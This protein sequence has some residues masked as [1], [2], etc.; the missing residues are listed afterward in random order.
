[1]PRLRLLALAAL[2]LCLAQ[3]PAAAQ[4]PQGWQTEPGGAKAPANTTV[5]PRSTLLPKG[6]GGTGQVSLTAHLTEESQGISQGLVWRVFRDQPGSDAKPAFLSMHKEAAPTLRLEA[7]TYLINVTLGRANLTRKI[8]VAA[9]ERVAKE[10]FVLNAGGLRVIAVLPPNTAPSERIVAFDVQS[11]ELD[12]HGQRTKVVTGAKPGVVLRLNAGIYS[13]VSRFGD[14][15]AL[16]R[17]DI[18]VE[19][20]K[21]S[22]VTLVHAAAKVSFKLVTRAGGDAIADTEWVVAT[23]QGEIVKESA[24]AL[25]AHFLAPGAYVVSARHAGRQFR[26]EFAVKAGETAQVEV[27]MP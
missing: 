15:N 21:L 19:A 3:L 10:R 8:T 18:S 5:V 1:M 22:E 25:P 16:A 12:Q 23:K 11:D 4:L 7:G 9:S 2:G 14:A 6:A 26:Q 20:G 17:A 24:G 13:I 27:V